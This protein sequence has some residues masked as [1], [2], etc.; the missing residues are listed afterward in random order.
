MAQRLSKR[1]RLELDDSASPSSPS[2]IPRVFPNDALAA[3]TAD[4]KKQWKG[5]CEIESEPVTAALAY[6]PYSALT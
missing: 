3:A 2:P 4:D 1:R 6:S 5:F